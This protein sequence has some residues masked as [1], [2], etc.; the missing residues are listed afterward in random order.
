VGRRTALGERRTAADESAADVRD[1]PASI[2]A[3]S[4]R[5]T[6]EGSIPEP[7]PDEPARDGER[8]TAVTIV[9]RKRKTGAEEA[10]R[11]GGEAAADAPV[12]E[13]S[14]AHAV[15]AVEGVPVLI[16]RVDSDGIR[17]L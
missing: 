1:M 12:P 10:L 16:P 2:A 6:A 3:G 5:R 4:D 14:G 7:P 9:R 11:D 15:P 8:M 17:R 13:G